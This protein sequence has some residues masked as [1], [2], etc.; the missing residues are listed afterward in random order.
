M[1]KLLLS[2]LLNGRKPVLAVI[3]AACCLYAQD[4]GQSKDPKTYVQLAVKAYQA[5]DYNT[6][7]DNLKVALVLRPTHETYIYYLAKGYALAGDKNNAVRALSE[8]INMGFTYPLADDK[9][10]V[11]IKDTDEFKDL[12]AKMERNKAHVGNSEPAF[13]IPEKGLITEGLAYNPND[14]SFYVSSVYKRKIVKIDKQGNVKD[15]AT[16]QDDLWSV[17]GM[18]VDANRHLL[19]VSTAANP[20][21]VNYKPE[22][23]G[24]SAILKYDTTTGKLIKKYGLSNAPK[25]HWLGDLTISPSGDVY[26]ADSLAPQIYVIRHDKDEIELFL[27]NNQIAN[28]QGITFSDDGKHMFMSDYSNG[29]FAIDQGTRKMTLLEFPAGTSML[30]IDGIYFYKGSIIGV[31]NGII[32]HRVIRIYLNSDMNKFDRLEVIEANNPAFSEPTLGDIVK[33][34]FYYNANS[35]WGAVDDK[36]NLAPMDKLKE[37]IVLKLKL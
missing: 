22:D 29:I 11:S 9:D 4:K 25:P 23:N 16:N 24:K 8:G 18:K 27:E 10:F 21:M 14:Q 3:L 30:G 5:K 19:W 2:K 26:S 32:P 34:T 15:F 33:D 7:I 12:I 13:T 28:G 17:M 6:M 36:G 37:H 1:A 31:Q 20:Q 35:Q